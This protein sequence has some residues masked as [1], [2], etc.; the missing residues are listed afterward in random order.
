M[1][2]NKEYIT[3]TTEKGNVNVSVDVISVVAAQA[4]VETEG[5]ASL[6]WESTDIFGKKNVSKGV[7]LSFDEAE[8]VGVEVYVLVKNGYPVHKT[9]AEVQKNV[10]SGVETVTGVKVSAVNIHVVGIELK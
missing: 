1:G 10:A 9:A 7:R 4:A 6:A 2:E 3:V 8:A 5:V